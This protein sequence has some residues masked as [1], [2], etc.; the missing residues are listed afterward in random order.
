MEKL[1]TVTEELYPK[2]S[3]IQTDETKSTV[4]ILTWIWVQVSC[5]AKRKKITR[6]PFLLKQ[7][8]ELRSSQHYFF[9]SFVQIW[10]HESQSGAPLLK[11][12]LK[13][14]WQ[15]QHNLC[16]CWDR[17]AGKKIVSSQKDINE[18]NCIYNKEAQ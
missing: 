16:K 13:C 17:G 18:G 1:G 12:L 4:S 2:F 9:Y 11:Y 5:W 3:H 10:I 8:F 14:S 15:I 7:Q 6:F